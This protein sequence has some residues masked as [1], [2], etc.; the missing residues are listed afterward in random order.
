MRALLSIAIL[1]FCGFTT[2]A[3][4]IS[5]SRI[6][7]T[8]PFKNQGIVTMGIVNSKVLTTPKNNTFTDPVNYKLYA[9]NKINAVDIKGV[10]ML[11]NYDALLNTLLLNNIAKQLADLN[12]IVAIVQHRA[13]QNNVKDNNTWQVEINKLSI[14][15]QNVWSHLKSQYSAI[16]K[17]KTVVGGLSF[18]GFALGALA[19]SDNWF[20]DVKGLVLITSGCNANIPLPVINMVCSQDPEV[21]S[22]GNNGGQNLQN[23]L[24]NVNPSVAA[25][26]TCVTDNICQ[27]HK[28]S[29]TWDS[30]FVSKIMA[31]LP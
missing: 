20:R 13:N 9:R 14:D 30:F 21:D 22:D 15:Y 17:Q 16:S 29:D 7:Q 25:K 26:S 1:L 23:A 4:V 10:V 27:L 5:R 31:W 19:F 3:Q 28:S 24:N 18:T 6:K 11:S 12:F 8:I 2:I